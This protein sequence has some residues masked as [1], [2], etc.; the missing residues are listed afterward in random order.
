MVEDLKKSI[1]LNFLG[2]WSKWR[3]LVWKV[4]EQ[5]WPEVP[6]WIFSFCRSSPKLRLWQENSSHSIWQSHHQGPFV[7]IECGGSYLSSHNGTLTIKRIL[8]L[9]ISFKPHI[10]SIMEWGVCHLAHRST[11]M[12]SVFFLTWPPPEKL[13]YRK[14]RLGVSRTS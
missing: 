7:W 12:Q 9:K 1:T 10:L 11:K 13:K 4:Y 6:T 14:P 5:V 8:Q 3:S 2:G